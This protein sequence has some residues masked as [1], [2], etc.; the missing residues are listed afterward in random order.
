M[1]LEITDYITS[2]LNDASSSQFSFN[3]S[4]TYSDDSQSDLTIFSCLDYCVDGNFNATI[5]VRNELS[6]NVVVCDLVS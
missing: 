2:I 3:V 4:L 5:D 6:G 1:T